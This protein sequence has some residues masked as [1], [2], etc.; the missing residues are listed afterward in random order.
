VSTI[1]DCKGAL[2]IDITSDQLSTICFSQLTKF[3]LTE[4]RLEITAESESLTGKSSFELRLDSGIS[5][6]NYTIGANSNNLLKISVS[7]L[8]D[9]FYNSTHGY[10]TIKSLSTNQIE[11]I[12]DVNLIG[13]YNKKNIHISAKITYP[14]K[15]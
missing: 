13:F 6:G 1:T 11:A 7:G 15:L 2:Q 9:E 5:I 4:N 12:L 8:Y 3:I 10:I 14:A